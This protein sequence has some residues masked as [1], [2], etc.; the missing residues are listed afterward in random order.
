MVIQEHMSWLLK[1][2]VSLL[3]RSM[4][5]GIHVPWLFENMSLLFRSI[6]SAYFEACVMVIQEQ[7]SWRFRSMHLHDSTVYITERVICTVF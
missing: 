2:H 7:E 4:F 5:R 6:D 1:G 3:F